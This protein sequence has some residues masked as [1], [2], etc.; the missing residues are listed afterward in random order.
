VRAQKV[1]RGHDVDTYRL[2]V[3]N[4]YE[5]AVA[6]ARE[7]RRLNNLLGAASSSERGNVVQE[8]IRRVLRGEVAYRIRPARERS[9]PEDGEAPSGCA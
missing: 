3:P 8:A 4:V 7:A 6:S 2:S 1:D 9:G 5:I